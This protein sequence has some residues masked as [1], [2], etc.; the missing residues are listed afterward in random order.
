MRISS[1]LLLCCFTLSG[2]AQIPSTDIFLS[3]MRKTEG[4]WTFSTPRNITSR[5]GYDNQPC[6]SSDSR[7]MLFVSM[8]DTIQSDLYVYG[9]Y[10]STLERLA[11]T[12][13][14]EYSPQFLGDGKSVSAVRV[15]SDKGQRLYEFTDEFQTA[16]ELTPGLDSIGYY[17]WLNDSTIALACLNNGLELTIYEKNN[18]QFLSL[19]KGIGRC[20]QRIPGTNDLLFVKKDG[21]EVTLMI[22]ST[23]RGETGMM[24]KGLSGVEDYCFLPDGTLLAGKDGK[25]FANDIYGDGGW[26]QLADFSG[27]AGDFYRICSSPDGRRLALVTYRGKKP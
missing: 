3:D 7:R 2:Y 20:L 6:F 5:E 14:S 8:T 25:L 13:E 17:C 10:D 21:E 1:A 18:A 19:E 15:D 27:S 22:Y 23:A 16:V 24:A 11:Q 9:I 4:K 26:E 12:S